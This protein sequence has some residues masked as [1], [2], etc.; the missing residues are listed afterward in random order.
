[1]MLKAGSKPVMLFYERL[2]NAEQKHNA[3]TFH[4]IN[5]II[6]EGTFREIRKQAREDDEYLKKLR[7]RPE[8]G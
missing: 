3:N 7:E 1:M 5:S 2:D 6:S 4:F 8:E